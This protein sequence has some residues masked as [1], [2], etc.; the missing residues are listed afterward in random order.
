M[1]G[2]FDG[3]V[4]LLTGPS[5]CGAPGHLAPAPAACTGQG[6]S[7]AA[8]HQPG[9]SPRELSLI[10]VANLV[11]LHRTR[12]LPSHLQEALANGISREEL[13]QAIVHAAFSRGSAADPADAERVVAEGQMDPGWLEHYRP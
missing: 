4:A 7:G 11:A 5:P 2:S 6:L 1:N 10:T 12:E 13:I 3:R 9:L 8:R